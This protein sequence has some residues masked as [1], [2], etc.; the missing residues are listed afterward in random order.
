MH[1][2]KFEVDQI[3]NGR[4]SAII[5]LDRPD[6][7]EYHENR[8]RYLHH[9]YKTNCKASGEDAFW[10]NSTRPSSKWPPIGHY[11]LSHG[12]YLVNRARW[13]DHYYKTK[14]VISGE[15]ASWKNSTWYNSKWPLIGHYSLSHGRYLV[16]HARWLDHY[17]KT[18]CEISDEDASWKN[19][20]WSNLKWPPF[21]RL[22]IFTWLIFGKPC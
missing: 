6:I 3:Q 9:Y 1:L 14:C 21:R 22:F 12:R 2:D 16:N 19:L 17:C 4:I 13:L 20:T 5:H 8:S 10:K 15:D 11:S 18:K 7:V